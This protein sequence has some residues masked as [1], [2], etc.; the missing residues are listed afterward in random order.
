MNIK[1]LHTETIIAGGVHLIWITLLAICLLGDSPNLILNFLAEIESGTAIFL[2]AI[3]FF[4]AFFLG[5][6]GEHFLIAL[7]Y[8]RKGKKGKEK[9]IELFK[10]KMNSGDI[11]S[12]KM[13]TLNSTIGILGLIIMICLSNV[14]MEAKSTS[15]IIG[16]ILLIATVCACAYWSNLEKIL[17]SKEKG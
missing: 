2:V 4:V 14:P 8:F 6:I 5:R 11:W 10:G 13:F 3:I 16:I 15:L 12:N 7:N 1:P 17:I 9:S